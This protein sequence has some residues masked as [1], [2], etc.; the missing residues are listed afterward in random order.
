MRVLSH[1]PP[2]IPAMVLLRMAATT[3]PLWEI[4]TIF[5]SLLISIVL[6]VYAVARI[7]EKGI[8]QYDSI[9]LREIKS[10][11]FRK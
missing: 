8:L 2:F 9:S 11:I 10:M 4:I 6:I 1:I 7:F 3:L 5:M